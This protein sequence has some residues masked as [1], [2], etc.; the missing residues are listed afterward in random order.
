VQKSDRIYL[1][2]FAL[3]PDPEQIWFED[4]E[5][6]NDLEFE[7]LAEETDIDNESEFLNSLKTAGNIWPDKN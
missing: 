4:F 3:D 2:R 6:E 7:K 5:P 1:S